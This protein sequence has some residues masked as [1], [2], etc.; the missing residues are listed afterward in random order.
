MKTRIISAIIMIAIA[1]P[2]LLIGGAWFNVAIYIVSILGL[3]EFLDIKSN[4]KTIPSFIKFISYIAFTLVILVDT[5]S[6]KITY[7][8]DYRILSAIFLTFLIPVVLYHDKKIYSINDAFYLMGGVLFLGISMSL[9]MIYRNIRLGLIVFLLLI[10]IMSDTFAYITG[11]YIGRHKLLE[12]ISP[13][14]TWEGLI[15]GTIMGIFIST[16]FY[17]VAID[18][19]F[20]I[21]SLIIVTG[22]LSILGQFGD[23]AFSAIKRYFEQK[24]FSDLIPGHGGI[25]DRLDSIIFVLLGFLFFI[26]IM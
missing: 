14:K 19:T 17:H 8:L 20:S 10:T 2:L 26:P 9:F 25:L 13:K 21:P 11:Y 4:K 12:T 1:L 22:F 7:T 3:K 6:T 16:C 24:D 23:L 5:S 18:P 15:C